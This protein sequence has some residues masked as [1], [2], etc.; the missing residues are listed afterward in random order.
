[1]IKPE[2]ICQLLVQAINLYVP[3]SAIQLFGPLYGIS[4]QSKVCSIKHLVAI[5]LEIYTQVLVL[6]CLSYTFENSG[7]FTLGC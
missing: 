6:Q 2:N 7:K 3:T 5:P 1:M 4:D